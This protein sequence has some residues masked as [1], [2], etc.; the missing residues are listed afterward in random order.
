M[1]IGHWQ[2]NRGFTLVELLV[3]MT[4]I[5]ILI[6]AG[7]YTYTKNQQRG[8]DAR[9]KADL[10]ALQ[11]AL[12]GYFDKNGQYPTMG[13]SSTTWDNTNPGTL[14]EA[15][16]G[17]GYISKMPLD[18]I[19]KFEGIAKDTNFL[20]VYSPIA[21]GLNYTLYANL[22]NDNDPDRIPPETTLRLDYKTVN[23]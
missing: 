20:Y 10:K 7:T 23:P 3:V 14:G 5:A 1:A 13:A 8:R 11:Q 6:G 4:I 9:R 19:N 21:T 17:E 15:L 12:E 18:P 16:V 2:L 22:E